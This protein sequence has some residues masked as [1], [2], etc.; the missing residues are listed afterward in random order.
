MH[1]HRCLR[2]ALLLTV[3]VVAGACGGSD[4]EGGDA[5]SAGAGK[6]ITISNFEFA[7]EVLEVKVGDTITVDNKDS[8]EHTVTARDKSFDTGRF[9]SGTKTFTVTK[10]GRFEYVCDVHPFMPSRVIQ[11]VG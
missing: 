10:A 2:S 1:V 4:E 9:A 8:A 7:P 6:T 11:V 5:N 3:L